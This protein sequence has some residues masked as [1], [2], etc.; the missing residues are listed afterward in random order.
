MRQPA[1]AFL[2]VTS[3]NGVFPF[4]W[5]AQHIN[6]TDNQDRSMASSGTK[7][8]HLRLDSAWTFWTLFTSAHGLRADCP[9]VLVVLNTPPSIH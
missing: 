5:G 8:C 2:G 9:L 1:R 3:F 6:D 7:W 4:V